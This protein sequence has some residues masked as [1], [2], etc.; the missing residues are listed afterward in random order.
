M[1]QENTFQNITTRFLRNLSCDS[2]MSNLMFT[3]FKVLKSSDG[4]RKILEF[5]KIFNDIQGPE[6]KENSPT[7]NWFFM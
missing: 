5:Y 3:I 1:S 7:A 4:F 2:E 6:K